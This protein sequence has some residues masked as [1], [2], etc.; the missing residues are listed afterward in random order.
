MK[1]LN[2][3]NRFIFFTFLALAPFSFSGC[4]ASCQSTPTAD[5][6]GFP[7]IDIVDAEFDVVISEYTSGEKAPWKRSD[8]TKFIGGTLGVPIVPKDV[9]IN[10]IETS[11]RV[12]IK[13]GE[14]LSSWFLNIPAGLKATGHFLEDNTKVAVTFTGVPVQTINQPIKIRVPYERTNRLWDFD[15]PID[16]DKRFE[17]YGVDIAS[18]IIGG[19]INRDIDPKSFTLKFGGT[20]L[21]GVLQEGMVISE[22]FT[23]LPLGLVA[24]VAEDTV[25]VIEGQQAL[26]VTISGRPTVQSKDK[27]YVIVPG[28]ITT[29]GIALEV[30]TS[31]KARYD[32]GAYSKTAY[33]MDPWGSSTLDNHWDGSQPWELSGLDG[34]KPFSSKDFD[35]VGII[36]IKAVAVESLGEDGEYHWQGE[37]VTYGKLMAEAQKLGAHAIINVVVDF[38]DEVNESLEKRHVEEGH[39]DTELER[40]KKRTPFR[41]NDPNSNYIIEA[42][43]DPNGGTIYVERIRTTTRT[44]TGTALAIKWAPAYA[45]VTSTSTSATSVYQPAYADREKNPR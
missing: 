17:V 38:K 2:R 31:E 6:I 24:R 28:S 43:P 23:N 21:A 39:V 15:I 18:V 8:A 30:Q 3:I 16:E 25:P 4:L 44:Y 41:K 36:Q 27:V 1:N 32:I 12:P 14:D 7:L 45:P 9:T 10:L 19:A 22:W 11:V 40:A 13:E 34:P 29:A 37:A 26:L 33:D 42:I 35:A 20:K 5:A